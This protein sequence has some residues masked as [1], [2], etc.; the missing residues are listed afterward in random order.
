MTDKLAP[1]PCS[2]AEVKLILRLR[3]IANNNTSALVILDLKGLKLFLAGK[4]ESLERN[5]SAS[6][7]SVSG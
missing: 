3:Q 7:T 6:L 4:A 2:Q 1:F 5:V